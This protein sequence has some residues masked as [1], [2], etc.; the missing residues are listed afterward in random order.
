MHWPV[1][2]VWLVH[3]I[4][5]RCGDSGALAGLDARLRAPDHVGDITTIRARG[6]ENDAPVD[7]AALNARSPLRTN[8]VR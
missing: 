7:R 8:A 6:R 5:D 2:T 1:R 4:S 3:V